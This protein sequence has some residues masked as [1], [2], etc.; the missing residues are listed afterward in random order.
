MSQRTALD[1]SDGQDPGDP[2][3]DGTFDPSKYTTTHG[4]TP[5]EIDVVEDH[6]VREELG[7]SEHREFQY[8]PKITGKRFADRYD[9]VSAAFREYIA[10]AETACIRRARRELEEVGYKRQEV[11]EMP[12]RE[13]LERARDEAGY[14]PTIEVVYSYP[15][16]D[17]PALIVAD[18][19]IGISVEEFQVIQ[20]VGLSANHHDGS[21]LGSFGQGIMSGFNLVGEFGDFSF[22]TR[23]MLDDAS[24]AE[25][26]RI[27]G[28]NDI[29]GG[30]DA[31]GTTFR[32]PQFCDEAREMEAREALEACTAGTRVPVLYV[33]YDETGTEVFNEEYPPTSLRDRLDDEAP[34]IVYEDACVEAVCSPEI[35]SPDTFLV[36]MAIAR[37]DGALTGSTSQRNAPWEWDLR[38]KYEDGRVYECECDDADHTG[39]VPVDSG[40]YERIDEERRD[41]YVPRS[42][43]EQDGLMPAPVDDRD[44]LKEGFDPFFASVANNLLEAFR[45]RAETLFQQLADDGFDAVFDL[46]PAERATFF[47]AY[48]TYGPS[49]SEVEPETVQE[50]IADELGVTLDDQTCEKLSMVRET[51]SWAERDTANPN[52]K[53]AREETQVWKLL[54]KAGTDGDV[55]VGVSLNRRKCELAWAL[56]DRN[57]VVALESTDDYDRFETVLGWPKLKELTLRDMAEEYPQLD[58]ATIDRLE[59]TSTRSS[60]STGPSNPG[61]RHI[62][63]R[64]GTGDSGQFTR[65]RGSRVYDALD[66]GGTISIGYSTSI[67]ELLV[68]RQTD[69]VTA[70]TFRSYATRG[71]G[72]AI[73]PNYVADYLTD[74]DNVYDSVEE[75]RA[76]HAEATVT[77]YDV[78]SYVGATWVESV[79]ADAPTADEHTLGD[80]G[81]ETILVTPRDRHVD[82]LTSSITSDDSLLPTLLAVIDDNASVSLDGIERIAVA[83]TDDLED[84]WLAVDNTI[85]E[86]SGETP[87]VIALDGQRP[88]YRINCERSATSVG[89]I[90]VRHELPLEQFPRDSPEWTLLVEGAGGAFRNYT[91]EAE[92]LIAT[93]QQLPECA[94]EPFASQ[95]GG[96][97]G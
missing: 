38:L 41:N 27:D 85:D 29:P 8:D 72:Y 86:P 36:S 61:S 69:D 14:R 39:L 3:E 21:V 22:E 95:Q 79:D 91:G 93:L 48:K 88:A 1:D 87:T 7:A 9:D 71:L 66:G 70:R 2:Q 18:N 23:S 34:A 19:G 83:T 97:D 84:N 51:V 35:S 30:R 37:N 68:L 42:D 47:R 40:A 10:N 67:S 74:A 16:A 12:V 15:G 13:V 81:D 43:V 49:Y 17:L 25:R 89:Q 92:A 90:R 24:Y 75:I 96:D 60:G 94:D 11:L 82:L 44:R 59:T 63:V 64:I 78:T 52:L 54:E 5:S 28:I 20:H 65:A 50:T 76:T 57:H 62:K 4:S 53:R 55:Y 6:P 80:L 77:T 73:V 26:L 45:E 32:F 46:T 56:G 31:Y 58:D 33:E